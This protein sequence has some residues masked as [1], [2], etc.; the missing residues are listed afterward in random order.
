MRDG[1][2]LTVFDGEA[3]VDFGFFAGE[4]FGFRF[5]IEQGNHAI[6][7]RRK[8]KIPHGFPAYIDQKPGIHKFF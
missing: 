7:E 4:R 2:L 6:G 8:A 1:K 5:T 3:L